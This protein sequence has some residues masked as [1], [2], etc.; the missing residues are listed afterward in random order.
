VTATNGL[1]RLLASLADVRPAGDG[2]WEARCPAHDDNRS[3]LSVCRASDGVTLLHCHAGC[4]TD[5]ILAA[6]GMKI[7]DLF[8]QR[9]ERNGRGGRIVAAYDYRDA[10]GTLVFQ[11]VRFEPKSFRQRK[12]KLGGGWTWAVKGCKVVP[13]RLQ[14]LMRADAGQFVYAP[15]GEKDCDRLAALGLVAT[16]NAG[17]AEKWRVAHAKFLANRHVVVLPDNDDPGRQHAAKIAK[18]LDGIAA[19][20]KVVELPGLP[21]KGDVSDWL[22][23]GGTAD[24]LRE[25]VEAAPEWTPTQTADA[26][27]EKGAD[28][29]FVKI[30]AD[31]VCERNHFARDGVGKLY[32]YREG[33]YRS[34]AESYIR[35][36]VKRLCIA[37]E[38]SDR[39][40]SRFANEVVEWIAVDAPELWERPPIDVVNVAN[41]LLCLTDAVL[42]PHT[43]DHLSP[44]QLPVAYDPKAS[45]PAIDQFVADVFPPDATALASEVPAW[46]MTPDT[47]VQKA[48]L[49]LGAGGNGK[50]T[51][52]AMLVAFLG[53]VNCTG[54]SLHKI[55]ANRFAVSRLVGKLANICPDLP[56][57]HLS[58][59][60]MFKA[61]TGG[62]FNL[63]G[64]VKFKDGFSFDPYC[65]MVF[66]ANS[67]PRSADASEAF[68]DRWLVVPFDARFRGTDRELTRKELDARLSSASELSGL[69]NKAVEA[70]QAIQRRGGRLSEPQS[71]REA[72]RE[73]HAMTDPLSVWLDQFTVDDPQ[74][75]VSRQVLRAAYGAACERAGRPSLTERAF[76]LAITKAR[77]NV[78]TAQRT[79]NGRRQWVYVG[80]GLSGDNPGDAHH[81]QLAQDNPSLFLTQAREET[82]GENGVVMK[83]QQD[84]AQAVHAV[85]PVLTDGCPKCGHPETVDVPVRGGEAV[86]RD[87]ARCG[88]TMGFPKWSTEAAPV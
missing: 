23:A 38:A 85:Q 66:S 21:D 22:A 42:L 47:S 19:S 62:D 20:I 59:T 17:G 37:S 26:E 12:P 28:E 10:D 15:E 58:G 2:K 60:S 55:E 24:T 51:W 6:V 53:K 56:T 86:R 33:A 74:A 1:D 54:L 61:L 39:W 81:A 9:D 75:V 4:E 29:G 36:E 57:E 78:E 72:W 88:H 80:I 83:E 18:S 11:A 48:V 82:E 71:V 35:A 68:F 50:S 5:R 46:L 79:I 64:E 30:V 3:S 52:L 31:Q 13:Y 14:E 67:A 65:R 45:C 32:R 41:G 70:W 8:R 25:L 49:L 43:P 87:C 73:F 16:T 7:S 40:S 27:Q 84:R 76:G 63:E 77:P 34:K 69:L 44:I